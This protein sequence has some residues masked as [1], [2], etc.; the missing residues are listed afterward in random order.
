LES[1]TPGSQYEKRHVTVLS[2]C[3]AAL[4]LAA[5]CAL[6]PESRTACRTERDCT[7]AR[8]CVEGEC[9]EP[10]A[11]AAR[12]RAEAAKDGGPAHAT[13]GD[14]GANAEGGSEDDL[15]LTEAQVDAAVGCGVS[16]ASSFRTECPGSEWQL[17]DALWS[18]DSVG[19]E[20]WL[21]FARTN[22]NMQAPSMA[23][24]PLLDLSGCEEISLEVRH[25]YDIGALFSARVALVSEQASDAGVEPVTLFERRGVLQ[26]SEEVDAVELRVRDLG[27]SDPSR[28]R[29]VLLGGSAAPRTT[30]LGSMSWEVFSVSLRAR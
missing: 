6:D 30:I 9:Q 21:R 16:Y 29:L 23:S 18:C 2:W 11:D 25:R 5:G 12:P 27:L 28:V 7:G 22:W 4:I 3:V 8:V 15:S 1:S 10:S 20:G 26:T 13:P 17:D 14:A 19:A 24:G